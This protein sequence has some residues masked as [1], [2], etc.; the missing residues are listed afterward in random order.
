M[1]TEMR[2]MQSST[3]EGPLETPKLKKHVSSVKEMSRCREVL[4]VTSICMTQLLNQASLGQTL[5]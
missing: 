4:F 3:K 5:R 2:T 1:M